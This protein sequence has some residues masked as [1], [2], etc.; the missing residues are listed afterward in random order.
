[1]HVDF[2]KLNFVLTTL[3]T[4]FFAMIKYQGLLCVVQLD[5]FTSVYI[6]F[7]FVHTEEPCAHR[8]KTTFHLSWPRRIIIQMTAKIVMS[9]CI[10]VLHELLLVLQYIKLQ[11]TLTSNSIQLI[12][13]QNTPTY[14]ASTT[15]VT[16][17]Y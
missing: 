14:R 15:K 4:P 6:C 9:F 12:C 10:V 11:R 7:L 16:L 2:I 8:G 3:L 5:Q 17:K 13:S 1:M